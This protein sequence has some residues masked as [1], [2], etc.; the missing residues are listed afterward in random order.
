VNSIK[1][2]NVSPGVDT[3]AGLFRAAVVLILA[4]V[5]LAGFGLRMFEPAKQLP[6]TRG[7]LPATAA[8]DCTMSM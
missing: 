5:V 1:T 2:A 7:A 8:R 6:K 4:D 3:S